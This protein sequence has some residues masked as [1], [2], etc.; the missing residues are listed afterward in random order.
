MQY[1]YMPYQTHDQAAVEKFFAT[2]LPDMNRVF[3]LVKKDVDLSQIPT[4]YQTQGGAFLLARREGEVV[5]T[6]AVRRIGEKIGELKRF[7]VLRHHR[8]AGIGRELLDRLLNHAR[9]NKFE[10]IRLDTTHE[11]PAA[12]ALFRKNGFVEIPRY[13]DDPYAELFF[14]LRFQ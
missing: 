2:V 7:Y 8:G 10:R 13:I 1:D 3:D 9:E 6:I 14:E 5:G 12:I 4:M 11:S